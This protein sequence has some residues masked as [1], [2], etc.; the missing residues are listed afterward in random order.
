MQV[1]PGRFAPARPDLPRIMRICGTV[2]YSLHR[3]SLMELCIRL[4]DQ[5][6]TIVFSVTVAN[7]RGELENEFSPFQHRQG[8]DR[9]GT[10][11]ISH[12]NGN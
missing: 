4:G 12:C 1:A 11:G 5:S 10:R 8:R 9:E 3:G 6:C 7:A 2:G